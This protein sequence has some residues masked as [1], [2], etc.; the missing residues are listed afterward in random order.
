LARAV[1][2]IDK[3]DTVRHVEYVSEMTK[4]P[5]FAKAIDA[6]RKL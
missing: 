1:F 5:D 4:Q 6:A 3:D 2:V